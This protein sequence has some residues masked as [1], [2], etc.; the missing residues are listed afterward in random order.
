M[1]RE[2]VKGYRMWKSCDVWVRS[3]GA[4]SRVMADEGAGRRVE[5]IGDGESREVLWVRIQFAGQVDRIAGLYAG[6]YAGG[7][8]SGKNSYYMGLYRRD[9]D[10]AYAGEEDRYNYLDRAGRFKDAADAYGQIAAQYNNLAEWH[11]R[12]SRKFGRLA[13]R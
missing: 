4:W 12:K 9:K 7:P 8:C 2:F 11:E 13:D 6:P 10:L 1:K 3:G 5:S